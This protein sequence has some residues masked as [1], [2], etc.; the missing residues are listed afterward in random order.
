MAF[1]FDIILVF[2][3]VISILAFIIFILFK[4]SYRIKKPTNS[5]NRLNKKFKANS[6]SQYWDPASYIDTNKIEENLKKNNEKYVK[7]CKKRLFN[8]ILYYFFLLIPIVSLILLIYSGYYKD[9]NNFKLIFLI[10]MPFIFFKFYIKF[11]SV[12]LIK[13]QIAKK[14]NWL[15]DPETNYL[16]WSFIKKKFPEIFLKGDKNQNLEDQFWGKYEFEGR[17]LDFTLGLFH[18]TVESGSG[19]N[20]RSHTFHRNY[21][22]MK[23]PKKLKTRFFLYPEGFFSKIGDFFTKKEINT[24]SIEFNKT[25]AFSY[26]GKKDQKALEIVKTLSQAVQENL[27]RMSKENKGISVLFG[28]DAIVF[29]AKGPILK[30][31]KTNLLKSDEISEKDISNLDNKIQKMIKIGL[32]MSKYLD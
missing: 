23:L 32:D 2:T 27:I 14:H 24:E 15:Y 29:D 13:N 1:L 10:S 9:I 5:I 30:K 4:I 12:D 16:R 11:L 18:Y 28:D 19:K 3:I 31:F 25:F 6:N 20:R 26:N 21:F 7:F 22:I 17:S 8:N